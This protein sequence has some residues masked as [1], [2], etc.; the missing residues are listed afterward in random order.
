M[1][2]DE[3]TSGAS[4][5][6]EKATKLV[7]QMVC[8]YGMSKL[9]TRT[10]G[11]A[12]HNIFLGRDFAEHDRDFGEKTADSIDQEIDTIIANAYQKAK[13]ILQSKKSNL[14]KIAAELIKV[15]VLEGKDLEKFL[16]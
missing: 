8:Q 10:F 15:E 4:N 5:D 3:I 14:K 9:G 16:V 1:V 11:K 12:A 2:F 6:I 7:H 13:K